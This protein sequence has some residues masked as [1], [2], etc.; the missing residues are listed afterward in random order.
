MIV[1]C[2]TG[3]RFL[4]PLTGLRPLPG[5]FPRLAPW[6][7]FKRPVWGWEIWVS[8]LLPLPNEGVAE[9]RPNDKWDDVEVVPTKRK[10]VHSYGENGDETAGKAQ[11]RRMRALPKRGALS[12]TRKAGTAGKMLAA[13]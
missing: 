2:E 12:S 5:E 8:I 11:A 10:A 1:A 13:R 7:S 3:A 4:A 6:A 9:L